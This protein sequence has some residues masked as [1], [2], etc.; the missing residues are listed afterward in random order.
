MGCTDSKDTKG[1]TS[2]TVKE[3]A[4]KTGGKV[5]ENGEILYKILLIGD[6]G[7]GKSSLLL[8]FSDDMFTETFISTIGV[9]FKIKTLVVDGLEIKLQ[10]WDTAGQERFRTITSSYYRGSHGIIV[11]YDITNMETFNNVQKWLQEIERFACHNVVKLLIG[12]KCD[13]VGE[14][15]VGYDTAKELAD[16]INVAFLETSAKD[17]TNVNNAFN[18]LAKS[19]VKNE[20]L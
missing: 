7:V 16:Q 14:R 5:T 19:L 13:L 12:N 11:V 6:S 9:D 15:K 2:I 18:D 10:I 20:N 1:S 4:P 8:R 17:S 3:E